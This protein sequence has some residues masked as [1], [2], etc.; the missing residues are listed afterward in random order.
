MSAELRIVAY[1]N[2]D[3]RKLLE[4]LLTSTKKKIDQKVEK[5]LKKGGKKMYEDYQTE[6]E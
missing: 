1:E 4:A 3:T 2:E 5:M 6:K